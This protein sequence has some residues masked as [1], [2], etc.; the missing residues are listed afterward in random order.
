MCIASSQIRQPG[1]TVPPNKQSRVKP[2]SNINLKA[3]IP[4][5]GQVL[6][7]ELPLAK[8]ELTSVPVAACVD[9][10]AAP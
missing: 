4:H 9:L 2:V 7:P 8:L 6:L 10:P 1:G 3:T 5:P